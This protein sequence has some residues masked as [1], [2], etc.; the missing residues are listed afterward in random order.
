MEQHS[1]LSWDEKTTLKVVSGTLTHYE[2]HGFQEELIVGNGL[3]RLKDAA[4][5]A[6]SCVTVQPDKNDYI[7]LEIKTGTE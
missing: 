4:P 5:K 1:T 2:P 3:L 6:A 7:R